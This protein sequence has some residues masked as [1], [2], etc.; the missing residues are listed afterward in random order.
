MALPPNESWTLS[1]YLDF[2]EDVD[3]APNPFV[4]R[5][6]TTAPVA[7]HHTTDAGENT[8][9]NPL[10]E[11]Q[12]LIRQSEERA[13]RRTHT[14]AGVPILLFAGELPEEEDNEFIRWVYRKRRLSS[15]PT[16]R[17]SADVA[18]VR[19]ERKQR[20]DYAKLKARGQL[21]TRTR[22]APATMVATGLDPDVRSNTPPPTTIGKK[23]SRSQGD[24]GHD[25]KKPLRRKGSPAEG[26][27]H[28]P[29]SSPT[30][31]TLA[32]LP[33][34]GIGHDD[35]VA[36]GV[37][38]YGT[39]SSLAYRAESVVVGV[40]KE[41]HEKVLRE[42]S[43]LQET[44]GKTQSALDAMQARVQTLE[45]ALARVD[46]RL[47]LLVRMQ[48]PNARPYYPAQAPPSSHETDPD[49]A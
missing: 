22:Y 6:D 44:L 49:T 34:T 40:P 48:Q 9:T 33:D 25:V 13:L 46:G 16:L 23:Y 37:A 2:D 42:L 41:E 5:G 45:L 8:I 1:S 38:P 31:G 39:G 26:V 14:Q 10:D 15:V 17:D 28:T 7:K 30:P 12:E 35:E 43:G 11:Q 32:T 18:D 19:L 27:S 29:T 20:F 3:Y 47:D 21:R 24:P 36:K 4:E